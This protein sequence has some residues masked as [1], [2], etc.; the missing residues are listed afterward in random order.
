MRFTGIGSLA[1]LEI[2]AKF[3]RGVKDKSVEAVRLQALGDTAN[4]RSHYD[5]A[6]KSYRR[7][8]TLFS[9]VGNKVVSVRPITPP[10]A[11]SCVR[12]LLIDWQIKERT[13]TWQRR[14]PA[15]SSGG[16]RAQ[17]LAPPPQI[18]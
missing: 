7:A 11:S 17:R 6:A 9:Q 3:F 13:W 16:L 18:F 14:L 15:R 8:I 1:T 10:I 5:A 12:S 4:A 2:L